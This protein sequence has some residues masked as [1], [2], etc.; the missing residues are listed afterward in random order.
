MTRRILALAIA[1]VLV[2]GVSTIVG[3]KRLQS[4]AKPSGQRT[5]VRLQLVMRGANLGLERQF[6]TGDMLR[7]KETGSVIGKIASV[8]TTPTLDSVPTAEGKL[9][10][11]VVPNEQ[12]I[13]FEVTGTAVPGDDGYRFDGERVWVNQDVKLVSPFVSFGAQVLSIEET[14]K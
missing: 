14:G 1:V 13:L 7:M 4:A 5:D 11:S 10:A 2:A 3:C 6:K 8:A 12:D 9:V